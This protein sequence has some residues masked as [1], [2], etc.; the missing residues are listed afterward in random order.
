VSPHDWVAAAVAFVVAFPTGTL[1]E[2]LLHRFLLHARSRT[3]VVRRHRLHHKSNRADTL[4]GDFR[5]FL[6]G[7]LP[8]CWIGFLHGRAAGVG[9]LLGAIGYVF[10]LALVHKLS[11]ERP[12]L[13]FWMSPNSHALHH[14]ATPRHNFGIVTRFWDLVF[15]TYAD[16]RRVP[17]HSKGDAS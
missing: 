14:G 9:F 5:D 12:R 7:M 1:A 16:R 3:F 11:H 4:W 10:L 8:F 6:P 15:G 17:G 2:Y 13:V